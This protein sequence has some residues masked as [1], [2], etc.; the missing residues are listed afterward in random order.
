MG[1]STP[2]MH[3]IKCEAEEY[4]PQQLKTRSELGVHLQTQFLVA[5]AITT[6]S[7]T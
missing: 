4:H 7:T 2:D 1:D 5:L 3:L 6:Q